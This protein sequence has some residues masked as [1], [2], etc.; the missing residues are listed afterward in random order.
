M[1][2]DAGRPEAN[3][4]REVEETCTPKSEAGGTSATRTLSSREL[5][6]GRSVLRIEHDGEYYTLRVTKNNRLILTK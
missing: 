6:A 2:P 3:E 1:P 4:E 5:L